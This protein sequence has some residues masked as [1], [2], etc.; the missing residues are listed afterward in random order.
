MRVRFHIDPDTGQPHIYNHGV[1]AEEVRQVL[2]GRG[3]DEQS[4]E[5]S[6]VKYGQTAVGRYLKV[7]YKESAEANELFVITAYE[8]RG[9]TRKAF[10][11][12]QRRKAT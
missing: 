8:L 3:I 2:V 10:R 4:T 12:R 11:R 5:G 1:T 9:K 6:R 7:I